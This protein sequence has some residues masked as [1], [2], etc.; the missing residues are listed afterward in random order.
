MLSLSDIEH[1]LYRSDLYIG[2]SE[3]QYSYVPVTD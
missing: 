2:S 3:K 1:V